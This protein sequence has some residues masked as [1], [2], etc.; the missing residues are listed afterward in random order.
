[1]ATPDPLEFHAFMA[2]RFERAVVPA[3]AVLVV[4]HDA[5]PLERLVAH[6]GKA[7]AQWMDLAHLDRAVKAAVESVQ[8][9]P[10]GTSPEDLIGAH[11]VGKDAR[12]GRD[13]VANPP[14]WARALNDVAAT[15]CVASPRT[16]GWNPRV[17]AVTDD[18]ETLDK[19][20]AAARRMVPEAFELYG[21]LASGLIAWMQ[22][23]A[24][25]G[26]LADDGV[27]ALRVALTAN[28]EQTLLW[29]DSGAD[30]HRRKVQAFCFLA[31]KHRLGLA[32]VSTATP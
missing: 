31:E 7:D 20:A 10:A 8:G 25:R 5:R 24:L 21:R 27:K 26:Y 12:T 32:A 19:F 30:F 1:M 3:L 18:G 2:E 14:E 22:G 6:V 15:F 11:D 13:V 9:L 16:P 28:Q 23:G 29:K 4:D 17:L